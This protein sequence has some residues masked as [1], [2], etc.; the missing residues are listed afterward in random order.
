MVGLSSANGAKDASPGQRSGKMTIK[1]IIPSPPRER[2]GVRE[3]R[4]KR[5]SYHPYN[6]INRSPDT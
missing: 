5:N 6:R 4:E 1:V 3:A 2:A